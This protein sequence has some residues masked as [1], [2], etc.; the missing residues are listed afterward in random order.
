[1]YIYREREKIKIENQIHMNIYLSIYVFMF[2]HN[3]LRDAFYECVYKQKRETKV[4]F[5]ISGRS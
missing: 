1:M 2:V 5:H 4:K 3:K